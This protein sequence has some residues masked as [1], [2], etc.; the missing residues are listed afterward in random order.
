MIEKG[1]TDVNQLEGGIVEYV[2]EVRVGHVEPLFKG[3]N[4]VFDER[5][6]ERERK[7]YYPYV[8]ILESLQTPPLIVRIKA[9]TFYLS[10]AK[11]AAKSLTLAAQKSV[12]SYGRKA[13][14]RESFYSISP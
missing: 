7:T 10:N 2:N 11:I 9:V 3:V 1:F 6:T 14:R 5:M 8:V 13:E 12:K 4:F